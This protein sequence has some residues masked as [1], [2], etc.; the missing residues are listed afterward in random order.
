M[1]SRV[2]NGY[3]IREVAMQKSLKGFGIVSGVI[4]F[5]L[6]IFAGLWILTEAGFNR[7]DVL[8]T[9][10]GFYFIGKAFFVGPMLIIASLQGKKE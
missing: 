8:S 10:I 9:G 2:I 7:E 4:A 3:L 1:F 6:C 5:T